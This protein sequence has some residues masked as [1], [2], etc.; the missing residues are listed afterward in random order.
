[1][2][3]ALSGCAGSGPFRNASDDFMAMPGTHER[4]RT[5]KDSDDQIKAVSTDFGL[6]DEKRNETLQVIEQGIR[7][8][9][10]TNPKCWETAHETHEDFDLFYVEFDDAG[11]PVDRAKGARYEQSELYR[12]Q[13]FIL[14]ELKKPNVVG[15]NIVLFTHG[16]HGNA[17]ADDD[18]SL[19]FKGVLQDIV[20]RERRYAQAGGAAV[21]GIENSP[22]LHRT[23]GIEVA[24]RGDS[25]LFPKVTTVWDRKLAAESVS[26]GAVHQLLAFLNQVYLDHSCHE[27]ESG[28]AVVLPCDRVHLLT[29]G[30][31][32]GALI[33][34]RSLTSRL[35][36][37][38]NLDECSHVT[39]FGDLTILLNPALEG[40]RY[41]ALFDE[42]VNRSQDAK[43]LG[44]P[45]LPPQCLRRPLSAVGAQIPTIVTLQSA[46]DQATG[47]WFPMFR[48]FTT[49][50]A[51]TLSTDEG[52]DKNLAI[53]W[54]PA[55]RTHQLDLLD[56]ATADQCNVDDHGYCPFGQNPGVQSDDSAASAE[57]HH[58][59]MQLTWSSQAPLPPFMPLWSVEVST[60]IM[61][62]HD[63]FWNPQIIRFISV[64]FEDAYEQSERRNGRL[65]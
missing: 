14:S 54:V 55:F 63:D 52:T 27:P 33:N 24:W 43:Y 12:V 32:F 47:V 11:Q 29:I 49:L 13:S 30:H 18:Y 23:V 51:T 2:L 5:Y 21:R 41:R 42:A 35:Q 26:I 40:A 34:F 15:L 3:V 28:R 48:R 20:L 46:G 7:Q 31:S 36:S 38:L 4:I 45:D 8:S 44:D 53:G 65:F 17:R 19:E 60:K 6:S 62:N 58:Q 59:R 1:V 50:F 10:R 61:K 56:D 16:W 64:L 57:T 37:G 39:G 9:A 25:L 22:G